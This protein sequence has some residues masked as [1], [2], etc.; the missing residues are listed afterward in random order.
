MIR[1]FFM[2]FFRC[3]YGYYIVAYVSF[4]SIYAVFE[5]Q[6]QQEH[7]L[8]ISKMLITKVFVSLKTLVVFQIAI[9]QNKIKK[10][11]KIKID[12]VVFFDSLQNL[13]KF[14]YFQQF[15][16]GHK[17]PSPTSNLKK[18]FTEK[19]IGMSYMSLKG[20]LHALIYYN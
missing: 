8:L 13:T 1:T 5:N 17:K 19:C 9:K 4:L 6:P 10:K 2:H 7:F 3:T 15:L 12:K 11:T 16:C 20:N 18:C 14:E